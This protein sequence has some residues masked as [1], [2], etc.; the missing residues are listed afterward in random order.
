MANCQIGV[1]L[2]YAT[3]HGHVGL[4]RALF[5]PEA[6]VADRDRCRQ[7]GIPADTT[8]RTKPQLALELLERALDGGVPARWVV[9]DEVY[10]SAGKVRRALEERGQAYVL[11][12]RG[13]EQPS[14]W[15]PYGLPSQVAVS[16]LATTVSP[17]AWQRRSCGAGAPGPRR[18]DWAWVPLRPAVRA[19]W[20]HALLLRRHPVRRDELAYYLVYTPA[21]TP[22]AAVVRAAGTRWTIEDTFKRAKGQVGLDHYEV[23]SW[24]GW[25]RH[26][27]L[28]LVALVA[29]TLGARQKGRPRARSTSRS[30][31]RKSAGCSC[32]SSGPLGSRGRRS[33]PG[34]AGDGAISRSPKPIIAGAA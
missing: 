15:P 8:H 21:D 10:G 7:A 11:A 18:Y 2:G 4:D 34:P 28:A 12:V 31:S 27:T 13:N 24:Q 29:L 16:E 17:Q 5:V 23:R 25:H 32:G 20:L 30:P 14:L 33:W 6:W 3:P 19:G 9:G 1:F 22:L 26:S